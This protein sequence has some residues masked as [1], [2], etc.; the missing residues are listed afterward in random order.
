MS[1]PSIGLAM[2]T[3]NEYSHIPVSIAQFYH[4]VDE[5]VVVDGGSQDD[6][7]EWAEKMGARVL[8]RPFDRDFSAQKNFAIENLNTDWV[9]L[10]DPDER[11]EPTLLEVLPFLA[12][13]EG[14]RFF[15][16]ADV[17]PENENLF[18]CIGIARKNFIDGVQTIIYPD[19]QYRFF[20]NYCRFE[21]KVHEKI[22]NFKNRT[23]LDYNRP[24]QAKPEE[25][26]QGTSEVI[27]TERGQIETGVNIS[28][29]ENISRFNILHY[30]SHGKQESQDALYRLI[31]SEERNE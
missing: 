13:E 29:Y 28:D 21:G 8:H 6:S 5:I 24:Y 25:R 9:Y 14:Q 19:Y 23:E 16:N 17:L 7:V 3:L 18:D 26:E 31:E 10:H 30:K 2:V 20:A 1:K 12:T 11:L 22:T 15:M 27:D 4:V